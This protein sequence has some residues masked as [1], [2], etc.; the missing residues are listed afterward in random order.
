MPQNKKK[1]VLLVK[2]EWPSWQNDYK[3]FD[4]KMSRI[5]K[6]NDTIEF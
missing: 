5:E 6:V 3:E 4:F 1:C 2:E